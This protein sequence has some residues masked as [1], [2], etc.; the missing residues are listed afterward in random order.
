MNTSD[1]PDKDLADKLYREGMTYNWRGDDSL[2]NATL[3]RALF[4]RSAR[5]GHTKALRELAEMMFVGSGGPKEMERA[6][7]LKW[8]AYRKNDEE[9]LEELVALLESYAESGVDSGSQHRA[10]N[11]ARKAEEAGEQ[12]RYVSDFLQALVREK[13]HLVEGE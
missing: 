11:A 8:S 2:A 5:L 10:E 12:L 1:A 6:L 13:R 9:A 7:W 3:A 4:E